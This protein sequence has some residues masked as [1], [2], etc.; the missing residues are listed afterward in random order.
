MRM[1]RRSFL[2]STAGG[3][4][5]TARPATAGTIGIGGPA[6]GSTWRAALPD[7]AKSEAVRQLV[8][9]IVTGVNQAMSPYIGQSELSVFNRTDKLDWQ[10]CSAPLAYVADHALEMSRFTEGAFDPTIGPLVNRFG[11]GPIHGE[12]ARPEDLSVSANGLRKATPGLTLD[13]CGIAKGYALDRILD[14]LPSIGVASALIELGGEVRTL[15]HHPDARSWHVGIERPDAEPGIMEHI[16]APG[17]LALATSGTGR[18]HIV[19]GQGGVSHLVEPRT[20]RPVDAAPASVSVLAETAM[21]ADGLATALMV[22]GMERG[23]AFAEAHAIPALFASRD[24]GSS[25]DIM[26]GRFEDYVVA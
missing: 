18:Q 4:A 6:F 15:G 9:S 14:G 22:M 8:A 7:G 12:R 23:A 1:T 19:L 26:T 24:S 10:S 21:R 16:V 11:F 17:H 3:M 2:V 13:L 5:W 20:G 25:H